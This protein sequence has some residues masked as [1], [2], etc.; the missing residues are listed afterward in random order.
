MNEEIASL[1]STIQSLKE[2][3]DMKLE[4]DPDWAKLT[5]KMV[6]EATEKERFERLWDKEKLLFDL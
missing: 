2:G 5:T 3:L 6:T 1:H 4:S